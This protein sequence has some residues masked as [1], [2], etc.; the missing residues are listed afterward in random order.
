[1]ALTDITFTRL[2]TPPLNDVDF[3][4]QMEAW[5]ANIVDVINY[6]LQLIE[7]S[8]VRATVTL[9]AGT[10][11]VLTPDIHAGDSVFTSIIAASNPGFITVTI[12]DGVSFTLTS[13]NGADAS[14]L[15]YMITKI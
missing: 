11:T 5:L 7:N 12:V 13:S 8:F 14:T 9:A 15:S 6:D 1:V 10:V 4:Y 2:D 3:A